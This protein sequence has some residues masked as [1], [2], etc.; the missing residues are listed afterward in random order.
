MTIDSG[1]AQGLRHLTKRD[2]VIKIS[3][4]TGLIQNDVAAIVQKTLE[5]IADELAAGGCRNTVRKRP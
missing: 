4:E 1:R 5:H 3:S 2:I